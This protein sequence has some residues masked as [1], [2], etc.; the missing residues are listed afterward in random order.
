MIPPGCLRECW[1]WG[2]REVVLRQP[3][4]SAVSGHSVA[5]LSGLER[6]LPAQGLPAVHRSMAL[7]SSDC[8]AQYK[9]GGRLVPTRP[10]PHGRGRLP[11]SLSS[12]LIARQR[13]LFLKGFRSRIFILVAHHIL[14]TSFACPCAFATAGALRKSFVSQSSWERTRQ[15][16]AA[17]PH[18]SSTLHGFSCELQLLAWRR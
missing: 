13:L 17:Q 5:H 3:S 2:D 16:L 7:A 9:C 8:L 11:P 15:S 10:W 4:S 14:S 6:A 18:G 12:S 1:A